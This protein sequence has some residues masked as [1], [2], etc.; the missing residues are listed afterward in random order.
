MPQGGY[1]RE[2]ARHSQWLVCA[3]E[4]RNAVFLCSRLEAYKLIVLAAVI[5]DTYCCCVNIFY[6]TV[7]L[8]S[9]LCTAVLTDLFLQSCSD[10]RCIVVEQR[11]GLAHHVTSHQGT[12]TVV[13]LEERDKSC[14]HRGN[15]LR[16]DIHKVDILWRHYRIIGILTALDSLADERTIV[17]QRSIT[18]T[19]NLLLFLLSGEVDNILIL[20]VDLCVLNLSIRSNDKSE[21]VDLCIHA[22]RRDKSDVRAL[23]RLDRTKT[24]VVSI[25]YVTYLE[26]GTLTR[27]TARTESRQTALMSNL[28]QRV[29]LVHELAQ[30]VCAEETVDNARDSLGVN[31]VSRLEHLIVTDIHALT[32]G[33]GHTCQTNRELIA[34]LLADGTHATVRQMVDIVDGS[35]RVNELDE[36]LN[37]LY[38]VLFR[39]D[40]SVHIDVEAQFLINAVASHLS[41]VIALI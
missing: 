3:A 14:R 8:S 16:R 11:N 15:L 4:L 29:C 24:A 32:D 40:T 26:S 2:P 13:M 5:E 41:K 20:H 10:D 18:L 19:D 17:V 27:Q 1:G 30:R 28:S 33:T 22:E 12:V 35:V 7:A 38:D 34:E 37:N 21:V 25:V 6:Y 9:N 31:K 39:Q 23:R 36:I